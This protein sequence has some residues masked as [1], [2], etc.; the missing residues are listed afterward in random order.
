MTHIVEQRFPVGQ[1]IDLIDRFNLDHSP[2]KEQEC[3]MIPRRF[4]F[5]SSDR[6][7]KN[8][9]LAIEIVDHPELV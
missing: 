3:V 5:V 7:E 6:A 9:L 1:Q 2:L 4:P 8:L